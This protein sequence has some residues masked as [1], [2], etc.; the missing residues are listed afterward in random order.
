[1]VVAC[2]LKPTATAIKVAFQK[3][4]KPQTTKASPWSIF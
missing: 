4:K 2:S 1:V 3:A